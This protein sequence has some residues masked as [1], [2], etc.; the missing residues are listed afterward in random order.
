MGL[1]QRRHERRC[2]APHRAASSRSSTR[3]SDNTTQLLASQGVR[4]IKGTAR[5]SGPHTVEVDGADGVETI[6][7]DAAL[8]S[9]GSRPRIPDW[10]QPDGD[11]ILTTRD[12]YPPKVFPESVTVVGSGVTGVEFVHM[13]SIVRRRGHARRQPPAGAA[14]QGS[15]GGGG[16]RGRVHAAW[17]EAVEGRPGG[18]HRATARHR[19]RDRALRRRPVGRVD[20]RRAGHRLDPEHRGHR[21]RPGRRRGRRRVRADQPPL[22]HVGAAHLRRRRHQRQ[23]AAV[24]GGV[25]AGPQGRRARDGPAHS[26]RARPRLRQGGIGDLHRARDRRRRSRRG[27]G[28]QLRAARSGSRRCRSRPPPR[29]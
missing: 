13:F 16:A 2:R 5:F 26:R 12:C 15:R 1:D 3:C 14:R 18:G 27:R 28:V 7:F 23:A 11:R 21:P 20:P 24:V 10:C 9:T 25:D 29:R 19:P 8:V 6:E 17:R 22:R 4:L